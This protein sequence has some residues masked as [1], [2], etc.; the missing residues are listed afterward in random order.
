MS[1]CT[2]PAKPAMIT[3]TQA[4]V[5]MLTKNRIH[6][7]SSSILIS[8]R[9]LCPFPVACSAFDSEWTSDFAELPETD[10]GSALSFAAVLSFGLAT[11]AE[12]SKADS[13]RESLLL[14]ERAAGLVLLVLAA[15]LPVLLPPACCTA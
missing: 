1:R 2:P 11:L 12:H 9:R 7:E 14:P 3:L 4:R 5:I 15:L 8:V 13:V 10:S 6:T